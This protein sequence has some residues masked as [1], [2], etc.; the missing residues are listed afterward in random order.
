M[1]NFKDW[2]NIPIMFIEQ[3]HDQGQMYCW[4][5]K[6]LH[7]NVSENFVFVRMIF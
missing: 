6:F 2:S 1:V 5:G 3:G 4:A 7:K